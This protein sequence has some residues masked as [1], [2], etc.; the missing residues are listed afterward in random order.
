MI[1]S[2]PVHGGWTWCCVQPCSLISHISYPLQYILVHHPE[3]I[4]TVKGHWVHSNEMSETPTVMSEQHEWCRLIA[5]ILILIWSI[6][7][8]S[9]LISNLHP[10][11]SHDFVITRHCRDLFGHFTHIR[12]CSTT[13]SVGCL[14]MRRNSDRVCSREIIMNKLS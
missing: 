7:L 4:L 1:A 9:T 11:G 14:C 3:F 12:F 2:G 5:A 13:R 8:Y 6:A 10:G